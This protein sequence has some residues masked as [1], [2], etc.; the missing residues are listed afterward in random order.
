[1]SQFS[2]VRDLEVLQIW[3]TVTARTVTGTEATLAYIE[4]APNAEV[5]EHRHANEQTGL[6]LR[7][8]L[9]FRIGEE[10]KEIGPGAM[11]VIPGEVPHQVS[12]GPDGAALAELFAPPRADW[13]SLERRPA[14]TPAGF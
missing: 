8:S 12:A 1:M 9:T 3:D 13:A 6:L 5:P 11:W 4:L 14:S 10:T 2:D 7:G